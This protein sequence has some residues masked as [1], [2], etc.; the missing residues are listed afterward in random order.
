MLG[1]TKK[2]TRSREIVGYVTVAAAGKEREGEGGREGRGRVG[3]IEGFAYTLAARRDE[4]PALL[5]NANS[6]VIILIYAPVSRRTTYRRR[7]PTSGGDGDGGGGG[8]GFVYTL[9]AFAPEISFPAFLQT[10]DVYAMQAGRV[11]TCL[12]AL[13]GQRE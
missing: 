4:G 8:G 13:S 10:V 9:L 5:R 1:R 2:E 12:E 7:W 6:F 3:E 11:G